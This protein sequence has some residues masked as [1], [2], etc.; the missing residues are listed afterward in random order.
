MPRILI[1]LFL[2]ATLALPAR[3]APKA[4][5]IVMHPGDVTYAR[6]EASGKKIKLTAAS[7][8][9]DERAQVIFTLSRDAETLEV[10]LKVENR[11]PQ[12]FLY[13]VQL[14]SLRLDRESRGE[15]SPVVGGKLAFETYP[16]LV[17]EVTLSG[18]KL[19]R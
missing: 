17:D 15:V 19:E 2:L 12:D 13:A 16:P 9:K 1:P 18:F 3:A 7:K 5:T 11:F 4:N 8:E 10:K 6:F 14:R